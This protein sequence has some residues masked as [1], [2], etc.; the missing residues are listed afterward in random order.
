MRKILLALSA[1]FMVA[2][3]P[4]HQP[5][6]LDT[7]NTL[8]LFGE[9]N[10]GMV[11]HVA[12]TLP[13]LGPTIYVNLVSPGGSIIAGKR[14]ID[15]LTAASNAGKKVV[16]IP[17]FAISMAFVI[18]QSSAC[19]VRLGLPSSV[20][21]QHQPSLSIEGPFHN[22]VNQLEAFRVEVVELEKLQAERLKMPL[23][24]FVA[25]TAFDMWLNS[26]QQA[27]A[28]KAVDSLGT[29][30]CSPNLL[31]RKRV[32]EV[33]GPFGMTFKIESNDCPYVLRQKLILPEKKDS[34]FEVRF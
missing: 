19:P 11:E 26:G 9:V 4:K 18:L 21:M 2:A 14:I 28:L 33:Q 17:H 23:H 3:A 34:K 12:N 1:L 32:D 16:C 8:T 22:T 31:K 7:H 15:Q 6:V 10:E 20:L 25:R 30:I 27:L 24:E 29:V 13:K 5:I